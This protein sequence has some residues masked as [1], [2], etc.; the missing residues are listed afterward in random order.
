MKKGFLI[1][2]IIL[3]VKSCICVHECYDN[4]K[5]T[6]SNHSDRAIYVNIS[7][8]DFAEVPHLIESDTIY[9]S[10]DVTYDKLNTFF[11][12]Y[13]SKPFE[14]KSCFWEHVRVD[15]SIYAFYFFDAKLVDSVG[16]DTVW[17]NYLILDKKF[18]TTQLLDS[19]NWILNYP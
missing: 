6:I 14:V 10:S 15:N 4:S 17:K 1:L 5:L 19:L 3:Q 9:N 13:V 8:I 11:D 2:M 16:W 18:V 7:N 12:A